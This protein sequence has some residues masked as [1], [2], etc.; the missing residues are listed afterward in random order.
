MQRLFLRAYK[1][2]KEAGGRRV[3]GAWEWLR[4]CDGWKVTHNPCVPEIEE[5]FPLQADFDGCRFG[6]RYK[7]MP[8]QKPWKF[9][10]DH[11]DVKTARGFPDDSDEEL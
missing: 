11:L 8:V 10:T 2:W 3:S 6:L 9:R 4:Y 7:G 1:R 5:L